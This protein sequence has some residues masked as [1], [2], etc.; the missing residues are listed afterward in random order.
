MNI[1]NKPLSGKL[2]DDFDDLSAT[3]TLAL[4]KHINDADIVMTYLLR[5]TTL[6]NLGDDNV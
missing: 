4:D 6:Q 1:A 2:I 3:L 5:N